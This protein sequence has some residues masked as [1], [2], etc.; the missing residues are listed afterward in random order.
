VEEITINKIEWSAPE[1]DHKEHSTDWFWTMGLITLAVCVLAV[2]IR[3][4]LFAVFI[5]ISG[6]CLAMF[7]IRHPQEISFIIETEGITMGRDKYSWKNIKSFDIKKDG[8]NPKLL[9]QTSK[10]F[11]PVY[12]IPIPAN[13]IG[14]IRESLLKFVPNAELEE[15]KSMQLMEKLGV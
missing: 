3:N 1:Y 14:Q 7:N 6:C 2:W 13:L 11:L 9:I 4:Y 12:T 10:Y 8:K 15:S 5:F